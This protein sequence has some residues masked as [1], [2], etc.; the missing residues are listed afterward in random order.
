MEFEFVFRSSH[1]CNPRLPSLPPRRQR[2]LGLARSA[3]SR[4]TLTQSLKLL[5]VAGV[6]YS[7]HKLVASVA[8][9]F[10][11]NGRSHPTPAGLQM[12]GI[13]ARRSLV[14]EIH[15]SVT[16]LHATTKT[17]AD[18]FPASVKQ[19]EAQSDVSINANEYCVGTESDQAELFPPF[20]PDSRAK[21]SSKTSIYTIYFFLHSMIALSTPPSVQNLTTWRPAF[22]TNSMNSSRFLSF[23]CKFSII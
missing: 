2:G 4:D 21:R 16:H 11:C 22:P 14:I 6:R 15:T 12:S 5:V 10:Q 3:V 20:P 8:F 13:L 23:P 17:T 1:H 19:P 7:A 9:K 18:P